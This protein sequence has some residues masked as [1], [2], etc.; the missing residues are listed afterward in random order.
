[1]PRWTLAVVALAALL[2]G[3][4]HGNEVGSCEAA[5]LAALAKSLDAADPA[6]RATMVAE[7]LPGACE[8]AEPIRQFL[9][10]QDPLGNGLPDE[11]CDASSN[12][13]KSFRVALGEVCDGFEDLRQQLAERPIGERS[14]MLYDR[15][16]FERFGL[17]DRRAWISGDHQTGVPFYT[18]QWLKK[19]GTTEAQ[20]KSIASAMLRVEGRAATIEGQTLPRVRGTTRIVP[21]GPAVLVAADRIEANGRPTTRID[22][23]RRIDPAAV[24]G[25][26]VGPLLDELTEARS[27]RNFDGTFVLSVDGDVPFSTVA[28]VIYTAAKAGYGKGAIV[29]EVEPVGHGALMLTLPDVGQGSASSDPLTVEITRDGHPP[30]KLDPEPDDPFRELVRALDGADAAVAFPDLTDDSDLAERNAAILE[31][32]A[33]ER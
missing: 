9:W 2:G 33:A 24:T 12:A 5:K 26:V 15:C 1:M 17:I 27:F 8:L 4:R 6:M 18:Y 20:A 19:R 7:G 21:N 28:D 16:D 29:V 31:A 3:C 25:H 11:P 32:L 10:L 13:G 14:A 22:D 23:E 30:T